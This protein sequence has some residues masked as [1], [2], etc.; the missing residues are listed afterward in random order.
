MTKFIWEIIPFYNSD[1]KNKYLSK[2]STIGQLDL[3]DKT[4]WP[5]TDVFKDEKG[6]YI[7]SEISGITK[8]NL[9]IYIA[10]SKLVIVGEKPFPGLNHNR[11]FYKMERNYGEFKRIIDIPDAVNR[12]SI[13]VEFSKGMLKIKFK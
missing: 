8:D 3:E 5:L 2:L 6:F 13:Q 9:E 1:Q 4:D 12:K 7:V 11:V 10:E